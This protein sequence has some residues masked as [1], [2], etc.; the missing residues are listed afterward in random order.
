MY[1]TTASGKFCSQCKLA[2]TIS[3]FSSTF[4]SV[5]GMQPAVN[6]G[7]YSSSSVND[8]DYGLLKRTTRKKTSKANDVEK[9]SEGEFF[10]TCVKLQRDVVYLN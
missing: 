2:K 9:V 6:G 7:D 10:F 8:N 3:C 4:F 1:K 5:L